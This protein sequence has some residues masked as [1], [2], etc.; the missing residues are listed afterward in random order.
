M[1]KSFDDYIREG[2]DA[3]CIKLLKNELYG[4]GLIGGTRA[5][6]LDRVSKRISAK[7]VTLR[8]NG[9]GIKYPHCPKCLT[10][11]QGYIEFGI[12]AYRV[13]YCFVCGQKVKW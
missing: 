4:K 11:L 6:L 3:M 5:T 9:T 12:Q 7:P 13:D 1:P 2:N 8:D 10:P